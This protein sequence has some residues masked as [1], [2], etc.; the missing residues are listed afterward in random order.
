MVPLL[1]ARVRVAAI[2]L[3]L[4]FGS[5]AATPQR[6]GTLQQMSDSLQTLSQKVLPAVVKIIVA[7]YGVVSESGHEDTAVIARQH[8]IGSGVIVDA[9]GYIITNAHVI[10][11]AQRINVSFD[12]MSSSPDSTSHQTKTRMLKAKVVGVDPDRDL[13]V[14]K[15][16]ATGLPALPLGESKKLHQGQLVLAFGSPEGL[17]DSMSM[18]VVSSVMRQPDP[19]RPMVY[20][21]TDAAVNPGNSGGPLVDADGNVVGI[22]TFILSESGGS[23]G[24]SF[25]IPSDTVR[26]VYQEVLAHGHVHR[27][28]IG[29]NLQV[30]TPLLAGGLHLSAD[31]GLIVS[32]VAPGGPADSAD[33]R[34]GDVVVA[35]D[36]E[37]V[38][39]L[40]AVEAALYRKPH[41]QP[42]TLDIVRGTEKLTLKVPVVETQESALDDLGRVVEQSKSRLDRLG[43]FAVEL[44]P[45]LTGMLPGLRITSGVLVTAKAADSS[46]DSGL[47]TG[48]V[49]HTI[50][51]FTIKTLVALRA[52][53]DVLQAGDPVAIQIEREG[54]L[55]YVAL[56]LE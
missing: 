8:A 39:G 33:L 22:N 15:V 42:V 55:I 30:V 5:R 50:N 13:A 56:E 27:R 16:E 40:P 14:L 29:A 51:G 7:G 11:G 54:R 1:K 32:D 21:Q 18:G 4:P 41:D 44:T 35:I 3:L 37:P 49:I 48:D 9:G 52:E 24:L 10:K 20:I 26:F 28:R 31:R 2:L 38:E 36:S 19:D 45:Q 12:E 46:I 17:E 47:Q 53:L 34:I 6:L 23:E 25:A 43:V